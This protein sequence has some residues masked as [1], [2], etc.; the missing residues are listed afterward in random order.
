MNSYQVLKAKTPICRSCETP[1]VPQSG[2]ESNKSGYP[3]ING[4]LSQKGIF[5]NVNND[6]R[7]FTQQQTVILDER[8]VRWIPDQVV[9]LLRIASQSIS[10]YDLRGKTV[11][12]GRKAV[13][14]DGE[15]RNWTLCMCSSEDVC[16]DQ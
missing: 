8:L 16:F 2:K 3:M 15:V 14:E 6:N 4:L 10:G 7:T 11:G 9:H 13:G 5:Q 12:G 1:I